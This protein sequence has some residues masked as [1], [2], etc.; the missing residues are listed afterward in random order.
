MLTMH[1]RKAGGFWCAE[2]DICMGKA[3]MAYARR[4]R[5]DEPLLRAERRL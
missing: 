5:R 1:G 2:N 4:A 3:A